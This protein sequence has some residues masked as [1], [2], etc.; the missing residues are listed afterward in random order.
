MSFLTWAPRGAVRN[1]EPC[2]FIFTDNV[3]PYK[4]PVYNQD[5]LISFIVT[6]PKDNYRVYENIK[7]Y[8]N[9]DFFTCK[10]RICIISLAKGN[11]TL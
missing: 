5:Y 8:G 1:S 9:M 6:I 10:E 11:K 2:L 3:Q 4:F 7:S